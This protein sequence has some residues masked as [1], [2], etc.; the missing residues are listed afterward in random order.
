MASE[1]PRAV[2]SRFVQ[3]D[4]FPKQL[5]DLQ[6][7]LEV[8]DGLI[9]LLG[10]SRRDQT[11]GAMTAL[12][13]GQRARLLVSRQRVGR[14]LLGRFDR[15]LSISDVRQD[16]QCRASRRGLDPRQ[17]RLFL[18]R[19]LSQFH[20]PFE[21]VVGYRHPA[22]RGCGQSHPSRHSAGPG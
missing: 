3:L 22:S 10:I 21:R 5:T 12:D 11:E 4:L 14:Q 13:A 2:R 6:R 19:K 16:L 17:A 7:D 9:R 18:W 1:E 20:R 15:S 8:I